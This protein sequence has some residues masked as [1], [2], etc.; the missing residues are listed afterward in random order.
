[1]SAG[2]YRI[3]GR[4]RESDGTT[5]KGYVV[6]AF[7]KD[8]GIFGHP[9]DRLGKSGLDASGS[10]SMTFDA[11]AFKDW[12][13]NQ[14]SVYLMVRDEE[15]AITLTTSPKKNTTTR[16]DFQIKLGQVEAS[17]GEPDIYAG[18]LDRTIAAVRNEA[19]A[20]DSSDDDVVE[21]STLLVEAITSW[22]VYRD[23]LQADLGYDG[24][25]VPE[26]PRKE[27]HVHVTRWDEAVLP[28]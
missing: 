15:G 4:V 9:D 5:S 20:I 11:A 22:T 27:A 7:D 8:P 3:T 21:I 26:A 16:M 24:I 1:M 17:S 23:Q 2:N 28:T 18:N 6:Q 14:P 10:F 25:Q 12:F 13:E 19:G